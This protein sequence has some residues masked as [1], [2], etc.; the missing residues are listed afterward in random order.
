[1]EQINIVKRPASPPPAPLRPSKMARRVVLT[2]E[3]DDLDMVVPY[4]GMRP[5]CCAIRICKK[6]AKQLKRD[7][8]TSSTEDKEVDAEVASI[9]P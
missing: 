9:T 1:M 8:D 4:G 5:L 7:K 6:H 3:D 2:I